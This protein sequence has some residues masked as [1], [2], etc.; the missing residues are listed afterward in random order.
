MEASKKADYNIYLSD[1]NQFILFL[2][3]TFQLDEVFVDFKQFSTRLIQYEVVNECLFV[4]S[5]SLKN[6]N[7]ETMNEFPYEYIVYSC[8]QGHNRNCE[9][10][11]MRPNQ[12]FET[13]IETLIF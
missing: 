2:G 4:I 10:K 1:C 7:V 8:K 11:G 3:S 9:S 5:N 6:L 12:R 13:R